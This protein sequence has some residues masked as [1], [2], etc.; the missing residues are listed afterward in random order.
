MH[1]IKKPELTTVLFQASPT[2]THAFKYPLKLPKSVEEWE[3]ADSLLLSTVVLAVLHAIL[4]EE[5]SSCLCEGVYDVLASRFG[6]GPSPCTQR[7]AEAK[8]KQHNRALEKLPSSKTKPVKP[9]AEQRGWKLVP[10]WC[11]P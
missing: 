11:N 6:T 9:S 4:A 8:L 2:T 7:R 1:S 5:K 3:E 10:R